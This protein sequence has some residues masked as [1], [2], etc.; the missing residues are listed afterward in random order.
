M[1]GTPYT[2]MQ[3]FDL[4][5]LVLSAVAVDLLWLFFFTWRRSLSRRMAVGRPYHFVPEGMVVPLKS[6]VVDP[7][8]SE[9]NNEK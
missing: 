9:P 6:R 1:E 4:L 7:L 2:L 8:D 5:M 3:H